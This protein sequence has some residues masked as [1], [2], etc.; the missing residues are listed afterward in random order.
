MRGPRVKNTNIKIT[1]I[2]IPLLEPFV[3]NFVYIQN[4]KNEDTPIE[5]RFNIAIGVEVLKSA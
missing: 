5:V 3:G 2:T 1:D 4:A